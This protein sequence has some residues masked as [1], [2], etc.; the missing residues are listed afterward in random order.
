MERDSLNSQH[1][2]RLVQ[3]GGGSDYLSGNYRFDTLHSGIS[4]HG[5]CVTA[6]KDFQSTQLAEPYISFILL[7]EGRLDFAI[8]QNRYQIEADGGRVVLIAAEEEILFSRYLYQGEKTAKITLKGIEQWL[9]QP[10]YAAMLPAVYRETVRH[11]HLSD[12]LRALAENSLMLSAQGDG[13]G[14]VLQREADALQLLAGLW[15]DFCS[16]YPLSPSSEKSGGTV[17]PSDGN[18]FVHGLNQAFDQGAHQVAE[19]A[20]ALH[21]SERTLQRRLRDYFGITVSDWLRHKHMQYA[22]YALTTGK[23]S[24]SEIAYRCGYGHTSSFTQAF[25]QYFDCT[26]A[27]VRKRED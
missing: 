3:Q 15:R 4:L 20:A 25:K 1:F 2:V 12:E 22:L 23:E 14:D 17:R 7:L 11:W 18:G 9:S 24:I 19:L 6:Q 26:P 16:R 8:N 13:L 5:G 27:E 10:Q 21:V